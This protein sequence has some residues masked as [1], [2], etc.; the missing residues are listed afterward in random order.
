MSSSIIWIF[1]PAAI[2]LLLWLLPQVKK[3]RLSLGLLVALFLTV[4]AAYIPISSTFHI[5]PWPIK[6]QDTFFILGRTL[7]LGEASKPLLVLFYFLVT[8]WFLGGMVVRAN[9]I[10]AP[11]GLAMVALLVSALA[12]VPFLYGALLIEMAVIVSVLILA[13]PG[14]TPQQGVLRYLI[15]QTLGV[16]FILFSGWILDLIE[17]GSTDQTLIIR[18]TILLGFGFAFLL[19]VFPLNTWMPLLTGQ[20]EPYLTGFVL[21]MLPMAVLLF[22]LN[23][24]N[25]Y[26]WLRNEPDLYIILRFAGVLIIATS[27]IE[28]AFQRNL[29]RL[30]GYFISFETGLALLA[31]G[32]QN[33]SGLSIF[34]SLF[35]PRAFGLWVFAISLGILRQ[36]SGNLDFEAIKGKLR[37]FPFIAGSL[38]IAEFSLLGLPLFASF[39]LEGTLLASLFQIS[40]FSAIWVFLGILG[41]LV[42]SLRSLNILAVN[43]IREEWKIGE[44]GVEAVILCLGTLVLL[45]LGI[46]PQVFLPPLLNLL[47]IYTHLL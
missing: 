44:G 4:A 11:L 20:A 34:S 32:L 45:I 29:G 41:L 21:V 42:A 15:F 6:I 36:K 35:L 25:L 7:T 13:P 30:L 10:L 40:P 1:F 38:L 8:L 28:A 3:I 14:Q 39:P 2:S 47:G 37:S 27:G 24:I 17:A 9:T 23:F 19:A 22:A 33:E 5:G 18:T 16:P 46:F 31:I 26:S 43:K 12:V